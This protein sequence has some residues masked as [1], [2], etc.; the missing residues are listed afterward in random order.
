MPENKLDEFALNQKIREELM[1]K[2]G[3]LIS[4][5]FADGMTDRGMLSVMNG[6]LCL[7]KSPIEP[8]PIKNYQYSVYNG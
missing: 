2:S 8:K 6:E 5:C 7:D 1:G 3:A 4:V